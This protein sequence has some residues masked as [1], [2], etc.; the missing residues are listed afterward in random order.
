MKTKKN[1]T[2]HNDEDIR[3]VG[4]CLQGYIDCS[5]YDIKKA[6]GLPN[7]G[8]EYKIDAQWTIQFDGGEVAT[9][10]NY[11]DGINY[12][13]RKHGT[14][15]TKIRDWHIGGHNNNVI[16]LIHDIIHNS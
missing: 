10:Y 8:D 5:Y 4:T 7:S 9:I 1:Y 12:C 15:K 3:A 14:P 11:K 2:T 13:G 16:T 6:F